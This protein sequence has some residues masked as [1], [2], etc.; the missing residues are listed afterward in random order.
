LAWQVCFDVTLEL[1][2][3]S[4]DGFVLLRNV[5]DKLEQVVSKGGEVISRK[6]SGQRA[7]ST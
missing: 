1:F 7:A 3:P 5:A 4:K 6:L 2:D